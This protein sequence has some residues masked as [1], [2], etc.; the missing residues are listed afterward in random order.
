MDTT[1]QCPVCLKYLRNVDIDAHVDACLNGT[2][3]P[4]D[5]QNPQDEM[6][7]ETKAFVFTSTPSNINAHRL[8][9]QLMREQMEPPEKQDTNLDQIECT[10]CSQPKPFE[11]MTMLN[12]C[13][14]V[15]PRV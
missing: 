11:S 12:V 4:N 9:E 15:Q 2:A 14:N 8:I 10:L 13:F 6:D 5:Y 3:Q 7:P 1:Q